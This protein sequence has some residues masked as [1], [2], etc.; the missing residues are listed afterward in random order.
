MDVYALIW[1]SHTHDDEF[2]QQAF[3][4]RMPALFKWLKHLKS[5][6]KLLACGG[7]GFEHS[8]GGL[9]II[10]A[11]SPEEAHEI[12]HAS[13]LSDMGSTEIFFWGVFHA[14]MQFNVN[15]PRLL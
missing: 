3:N 10:L 5:Q 8:P 7:G 11:K 9:T 4:D 12:A 13:P 14:D 2:D 15:D 1:R 6:S